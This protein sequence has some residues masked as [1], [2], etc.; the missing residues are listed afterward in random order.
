VE[1]AAGVLKAL[2]RLD[3]REQT[4]SIEC[5]AAT[6]VIMAVA[7]EDIL[8]EL[9]LPVTTADREGPEATFIKR[10]LW[11][12]FIPRFATPLQAEETKERVHLQ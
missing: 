1:V 5:M 6:P 12:K 8:E 2:L 10:H 7:V 11:S 4:L 3:F 9:P